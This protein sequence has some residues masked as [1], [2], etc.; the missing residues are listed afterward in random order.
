LAARVIA[1]V[2]A[3]GPLV[4]VGT[5]TPPGYGASPRPADPTCTRDYASGQVAATRGL[6]FGIDPEPAGSLGSGQHEVRPVN[7]DR[8]LRRCVRCV[9]PARSW[10]CGSAGCSKPTASPGYGAFTRSSPATRA[11]DTLA[12]TEARLRPEH[13]ELYSAQFAGLRKSTKMIQ[14]QAVPVE[15]VVAVIER[16]LTTER[17]RARYPVGAASKIQLAVGAVLPTAFMDAA[18]AKLAKPVRPR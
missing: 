14:K 4:F 15:D 1:L 2:A 11:L 13:R 17:P 12:G 7:A 18:L 5:S 10:C 16:A 9:R 8:A 6:R 3:I